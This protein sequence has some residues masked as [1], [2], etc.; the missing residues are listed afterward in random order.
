[1]MIKSFSCSR[2]IPGEEHRTLAQSQSEA[3]SCG[4]GQIAFFL[5][6]S[7]VFVDLRFTDAFLD[8]MCNSSCD[9]DGQLKSG[10]KLP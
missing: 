2:D 3:S 9:M 10:Q 8:K 7:L 1:M 6:S 4:E 5:N